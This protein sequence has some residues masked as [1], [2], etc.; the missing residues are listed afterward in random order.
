[1]S[2]YTRLKAGEFNDKLLKG[3]R[4]PVKKSTRLERDELTGHVR[5]VE[6]RDEELER[7]MKWVRDRISE[8]V[9]FPLRDLERVRADVV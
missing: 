9:T 7:E 6:E 3:K 8:L 2:I 4:K 5:E 1:L